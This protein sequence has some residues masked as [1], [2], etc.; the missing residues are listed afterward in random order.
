[1]QFS[2]A[3][4]DN[5]C[6]RFEK[7]RQL[8]FGTGL[9]KI[10]AIRFSCTQQRHGKQYSKFFRSRPDIFGLGTTKARFGHRLGTGELVAD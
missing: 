2:T 4:V 7:T 3:F 6:R 5:P 8:K 10:E 9:N 1:M